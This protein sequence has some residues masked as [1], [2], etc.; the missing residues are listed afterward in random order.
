ME[1]GEGTPGAVESSHLKVTTFAMEVQ[2]AAPP[3]PTTSQALSAPGR[4]P[5]FDLR[6]H[7]PWLCLFVRA[8]QM[9]AHTIPLE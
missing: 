5:W 8:S 2:W 7:L 9:F 1:V 4:A 6:R 3:A